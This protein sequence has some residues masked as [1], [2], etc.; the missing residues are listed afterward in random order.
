AAAQSMLQL[1][2]NDP[3]V[4]SQQSLLWVHSALGDANP[5]VRETAVEILAQDTTHDVAPVL[6]ELVRDSSALV[7]QHAVRALGL[8]AAT[9]PLGALRQA[10]ADSQAAVRIEAIHAFS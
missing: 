7:R 5:A 4:L 10:L 1:I 3:V 2:T 9:A 6:L 8:R